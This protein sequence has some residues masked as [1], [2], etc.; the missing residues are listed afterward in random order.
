MVCIFVEAS[1]GF[2]FLN[3]TTIIAFQYIEINVHK[4]KKKEKNIYISSYSIISLTL[5]LSPISST[6]SVSILMKN[7]SSIHLGFYFLYMICILYYLYVEKKSL[8]KYK[9]INVFVYLLFIEQIMR[10]QQMSPIIIVFAGRYGCHNMENKCPFVV[11]FFFFLVF[12]CMST[13]CMLVM[14]HAEY[15]KTFS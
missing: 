4:T 8:F 5:S 6:C 15:L 10:K 2:I 11:V 1:S 13:I 9:S 14:L 7:L 3:I 12:V